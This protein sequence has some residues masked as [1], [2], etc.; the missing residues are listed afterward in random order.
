MSEQQRTWIEARLTG[1]AGAEVLDEMPGDW[2][3]S[4]E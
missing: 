3:G 1:I 2:V 4:V